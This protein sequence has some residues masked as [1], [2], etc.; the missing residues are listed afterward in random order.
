MR[1]GHW[2]SNDCERSTRDDT[3]QLSYHLY[4]A[5]VA[6]YGKGAVFLDVS[7]IPPGENFLQMIDDFILNCDLMLAVVGKRWL[8]ASDGQGRKL[9]NPDD[10]LRR[11]LLQLLSNVYDHGMRTAE[12]TRS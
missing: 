7:T 3:G 5:L 8:D 12:I 10:L 4:E 9:D 1:F 2:T 6:S 11:E